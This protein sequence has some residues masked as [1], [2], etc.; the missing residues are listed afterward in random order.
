MQ[1][2]SSPEEKLLNLIKRKRGGRPP[3]QKDAS[4][5]PSLDEKHVGA[6]EVRIKASSSVIDFSSIVKHEYVRLFNAVLF[7]ALIV[8]ILYFLVDT[9]FFPAEGPAVPTEVKGVEATAEII[10][11]IEVKPYAYYSKNLNKNV[12]KAPVRKKEKVIPEIPIEEIMGDLAVLGI[13]SGDSPQAIIEN[14]KQKK[15]F[16]LKRGQAAGG[17]LLKEIDT[18]SVTV[19]YKGEEFILTL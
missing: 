19:V 2:E 7:I 4:P 16:F 1:K 5:A 18:D 9:I 13:V 11:E 10:K 6:K 14:K 15:S 8:V 3:E 12:F 17:V